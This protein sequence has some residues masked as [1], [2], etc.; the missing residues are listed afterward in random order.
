MKTLLLLAASAVSLGACTPRSN[1]PQRVSLDCPSAEGKLTRL[2]EA[3]DGK[4]C[5][6]RDPNGGQVELRLVSVAGGLGATLKA[7]ENELLPAPTEAE[8]VE[9]LALGDAGGGIHVTEGPDGDKVDIDI[10]GFRIQADNENANIKI[11][12]MTVNAGGENAVIRSQED[13]R[14]K[15]ESLSREKR[16]VRA[17]YLR[18]GASLP[19]DWRYVGYEA[20]GPKAGPLAVA[21]IRSK[22]DHETVIA[23]LDN[24][25]K[26]LVRRNGGV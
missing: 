4:S 7:L 3:A 9:A 6:Y 19:G 13:V 14:L 12:P 17:S 20:A 11:G 18:A 10:P 26:R 22:S 5:V 23:G 24:D 21:M 8:Q 15:G 16:G 1:P 2:S 25:L